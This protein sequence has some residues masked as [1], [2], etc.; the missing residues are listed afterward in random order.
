MLL[1]TLIIALMLHLKSLRRENLRYSAFFHACETPALFIDAKET[2][3]DLNASAQ[4]LLG[5]SPTQLSGLKWF[6][7][8]LP[9][10]TRF[11]SGDRAFPAV[12]RDGEGSFVS[13]L[14]CADGA[15]TE[16]KFT[17][18]KLPEPLKGTILTLADNSAPCENM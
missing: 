13:P 15:V 8:L 3:R 18:T 6:E 1:F 14:L 17:V 5:Y 16:M 11:R 9:E 2:I 4:G 10:E 12:W 7:K